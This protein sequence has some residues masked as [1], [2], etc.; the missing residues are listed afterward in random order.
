MPIGVALVVV[1][2][3]DQ[4]IFLRLADKVVGRSSDVARVG[5]LGD[6]GAATD[7]SRSGQSSNRNRVGWGIYFD[8]WC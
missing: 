5:T 6:R 2:V 7:E 4:A 3:A 1:R 8:D